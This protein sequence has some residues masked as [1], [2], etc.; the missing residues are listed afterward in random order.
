MLLTFLSLLLCGIF[1]V[2]RQTHPM[3][4]SAQDRH[5]VGAC[6]PVDQPKSVYN[7]SGV[8]LPE[9]QWLWNENEEAQ[10]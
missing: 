10:I 8:S 9:F 2:T 3:H 5:T 7:G 4:I 6:S 1:F